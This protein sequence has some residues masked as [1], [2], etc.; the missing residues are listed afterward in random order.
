MHKS[1]EEYKNGKSHTI[2]HFYGKLLLLKD[3]MN[4]ETARKIA[5]GR[6]KYMEEFLKKFY[7]EWEGEE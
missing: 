7:K 3:L 5:E 2:N 6:H 1:F 4:T